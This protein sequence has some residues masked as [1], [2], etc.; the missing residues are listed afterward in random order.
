MEFITNISNNTKVCSDL[1]HREDNLQ[2]IY[3][4]PFHF[5]HISYCHL[6]S[7]HHPCIINVVSSHWSFLRFCLS[8]LSTF[9]YSAHYLLF[10]VIKQFIF[11]ISLSV[12]GYIYI[13]IYLQSHMQLSV[14]RS[15]R[16]HN[17]CLSLAPCSLL[18]E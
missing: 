18:V 17:I 10:I 12:F 3:N 9:D 8:H 14:S 5:C 7:R 11:N 4:R 15:V 6:M 13:F 1:I 16:S 2:I